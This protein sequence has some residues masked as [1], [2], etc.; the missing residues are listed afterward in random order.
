MEI[1]MSAARFLLLTGMLAIAWYGPAVQATEASAAD[2]N[3][4]V[5]ASF[6]RA[7]AGDDSTAKREAV[8]AVAALGKRYDDVVLA[9]LVQATNDRQTHDEAVLVLRVR[10][11]LSPNFVDRGSGYPNYPTS[12]AGRDWSAWL[13]ARSQD[14]RQWRLL[15]LEEQQIKELQAERAGRA[16]SHASCADAPVGAGAP[17]DN[18]DAGQHAP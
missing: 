18:S 1:V 16:R 2:P 5:I 8:R 10:T 15:Q 9:L 12:D 14:Q 11:G 17:T 13:V 7:F 4:T 6:V 3:D